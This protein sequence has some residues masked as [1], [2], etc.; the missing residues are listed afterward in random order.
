MIHGIE[1]FAVQNVRVRGW[2]AIRPIAHALQS[3]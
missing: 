2:A 1:P 3:G